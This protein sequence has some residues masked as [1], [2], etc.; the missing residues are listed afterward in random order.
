MELLLA[1]CRLLNEGLAAEANELQGI[2]AEI[3]KSS[4]KSDKINEIKELAEKAT[5]G[6]D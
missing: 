1:Q 6:K 3:D 5:H 4:E 2:F